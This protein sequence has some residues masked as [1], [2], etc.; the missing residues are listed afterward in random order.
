MRIRWALVW[1]KRDVERGK[2]GQ[3]EEY[4]HNMLYELLNYQ[5]LNLKMCTQE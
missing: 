2:N 5:K 4:D 1:E 3:R